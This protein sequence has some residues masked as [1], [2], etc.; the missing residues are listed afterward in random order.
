MEN[1]PF[2]SVAFGGF[3]KQDVVDYIE[4]TA[5]EATQ[6]QEELCQKNEDLRQE[7]EALRA[8]VEELERSEKELR[9]KN[10]A[11]AR[12]RETLTGEL[13]KER[14]A[15][16]KLEAIQAEADALREETERLRPDAQA[17]AQFRERLGA[18]ECEARKRAADLEANTIAQMEKALSTFRS[19]YQEAAASFDAKAVHVTG[20]L[21]KVEVNLSQLP[22][23][24]DQTSTDLK[25]LAEFLEKTKSAQ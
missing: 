19:L 12:E 20:E 1:N 25:E 14:A 8:R 4:R 24:L 10:D 16:Q 11:L 17:Y 18:I 21:R 15:R 6:A 22:R 3:A 2:R 23:A 5:K 9:E 13:N 7:A